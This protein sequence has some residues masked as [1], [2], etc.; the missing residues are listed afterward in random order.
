MIINAA[1][2]KIL[3]STS[4]TLEVLRDL[5]LEQVD[6][7]GYLASRITSDADC[8]GELKIRLAMSMATMVKLTK[9]W[10]SKAVSPNTNYDR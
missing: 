10:K 1:K 8:K 3:V 2:T 6:L 4:K 9:M 7:F 5:Q